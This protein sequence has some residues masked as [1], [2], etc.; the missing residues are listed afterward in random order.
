MYQMKQLAQL[1]QKESGM[2]FE[3]DCSEY[4]FEL[5]KFI[6]IDGN[7]MDILSFMND[8]NKYGYTILFKFFIEKACGII[9]CIADSCGFF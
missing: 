9:V 2:I 5:V 3:F 8:C 4:P 6:D 1:I 7:K